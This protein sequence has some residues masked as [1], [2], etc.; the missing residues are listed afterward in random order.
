MSGPTASAGKPANLDE[1]LRLRAAQIASEAERLVRQ[2]PALAGLSRR[3]QVELTRML[4]DWLSSI[5]GAELRQAQ[6]PLVHPPFEPSARRLDGSL[7]VGR[8]LALLS[9]V[10]GAVLL[11]WSRELQ[12][13]IPIPE[14]QA[15]GRAIDQIATDW[16]RA[17]VEREAGRQCE[18]FY[19]RLAGIV[20][21]DLRNPL[22]A[23]ALSSNLMLQRGETLPAFALAAAR[24]ISTSADRMARMVGQL[25]DFTR[26]RMA[27]GLPVSLRPTNLCEIARAVVDELAVLRP[28]QLELSCPTVGVRGEW[29]PERLFQVLSNLVSNALEHGAEGMPVELVLHNQANQALIEVKNQG[30]PIPADVLQRLFDPFHRVGADHPGSGLG[31]GLYVVQQVLLAHGGTIEVRSTASEGTTFRVRLP[32]VPV[33]EFRR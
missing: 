17:L 16:L 20:G 32:R 6:G 18:Q 14:A 26:A 30:P 2:H 31:L 24:R 29:D 4:V 1:L 22:G 7:N 21:R 5:V 10:R 9:A 33:D 11:V 13:A 3:E 23:I 8:A 25:L 28:G 12:P 19:E 15:L 27:G